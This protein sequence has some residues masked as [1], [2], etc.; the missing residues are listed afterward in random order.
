M[1]IKNKQENK[2]NKTKIYNKTEV[3]VDASLAR[4]KW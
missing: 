3:V 4:K 1:Y 2:I